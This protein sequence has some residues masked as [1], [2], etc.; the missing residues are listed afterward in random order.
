MSSILET[1]YETGAWYAG[2]VV[3]ECTWSAVIPSRNCDWKGSGEQH[4]TAIKVG[5][6]GV[7]ILITVGATAASLAVPQL[8]LPMMAARQL[9]Y[10][11]VTIWLIKG[12]IAGTS[13]VLNDYLTKQI[14]GNV[15]PD[16]AK[17]EKFV[18]D[19]ESRIGKVQLVLSIG[20]FFIDIPVEESTCV[21]DLLRIAAI[22]AYDI[23]HQ[24]NE[25]IQLE[26]LEE[27]LEEDWQQ[28]IADQKPMSEEDTVKEIPADVQKG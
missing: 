17:R 16:K 20:R 1:F 11:Q 14:N 2:K 13:V 27:P 6:L 21:V 3:G 18:S 19:F 22:F 26:P 8:I 23:K 7:K 9:A 4:A 12:V 15:T 24:E 5:L 10:S 28:I 25:Y